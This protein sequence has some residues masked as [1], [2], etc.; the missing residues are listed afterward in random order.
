MPPR[1]TQEGQAVQAVQAMC[2]MVMVELV[3]QLLHL[4]ELP[5]VSLVLE[6]VGELPLC[7]LR[8]GFLELDRSLA[9]EEHRYFAL[10][11][12]VVTVASEEARSRVGLL[13]LR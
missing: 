12:Q 10:V 5:L 2:L 9:E 11:V 13:P 6:E 4:G 8:I 1:S 7:F 3:E